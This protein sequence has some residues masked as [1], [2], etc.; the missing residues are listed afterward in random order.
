MS[1]DGLGN[2]RDVCDC[3]I[4]PVSYLE[5]TFLAD[6][7][8]P[9]DDFACNTFAAKFWSDVDV[10]CNSYGTFYS[11]RPSRN[12]LTDD[13]NVF[14]NDVDSIAVNIDWACSVLLEFSNLFLSELA[15][16]ISYRLHHLAKLLTHDTEVTL[17][18]LYEH[19]GSFHKLEFL[20]IYFVEDK[21]LHF[22]DICLLSLVCD[23]NADAL[24]WLANNNLFLLS[25]RQNH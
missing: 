21:L 2:L 22:I 20:D 4:Y 7:L 11:N 23:R 18:F 6:S 3:D 8:N 9:L 16:C 10:E 13:F 5:S 25:E 14:E 12:V 15:D 17:N 1:A 24:Q 19:S